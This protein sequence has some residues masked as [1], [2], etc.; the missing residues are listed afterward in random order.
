MSE[1]KAEITQRHP[2]DWL[3]NGVLL[4][5]FVVWPVLFLT[6]LWDAVNQ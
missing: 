4:T 3:A 6:L 1:E 2:T 5:I